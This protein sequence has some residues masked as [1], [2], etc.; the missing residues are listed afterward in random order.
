MP[1]FERPT[2]I[3]HQQDTFGA[4]EVGLTHPSQSTH[5]RLRDN[6]DVEIIAGDGVGIVLSAARKTITFFADQIKLLTNE[7]NGL[8]WNANAFNIKATSFSQP[9]LV[10]FMEN[11]SD[12]YADADYYS[13]EGSVLTHPLDVNGSLDG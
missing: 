10:P 8:R 3:M 4:N 6:G 9:A 12:L 5:V 11:H 1:R 13:P 7:D 2:G